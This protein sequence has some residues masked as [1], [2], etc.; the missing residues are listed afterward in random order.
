ML[1]HRSPGL[2]GGPKQ[3]CREP[4]LSWLVFPV[5]GESRG[6]GWSVLAKCAAITQQRGVVEGTEIASLLL[7]SMN[8]T[9]P[10]EDL[11]LGMGYGGS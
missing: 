7:S 9:I 8:N 2:S 6:L 10:E 4:A 3:G 11:A 1:G 5:L